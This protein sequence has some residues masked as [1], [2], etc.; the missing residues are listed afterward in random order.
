MQR[1]DRLLAVLLQLRAGKAVTAAELAAR[2]EVSVR[3]VYRDMDALSSL[4]VPVYAEKG[5][6]GGFRLL[7]GYFL[8]A[9][10]FTRDEAVALV[11][12]LTALRSLRVRPFDAAL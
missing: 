7:E 4:G 5:P 2:L 3:T 9:I 10:A 6:R 8:P 11:L 12:A 1:S